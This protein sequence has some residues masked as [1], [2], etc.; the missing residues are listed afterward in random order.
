MK[1]RIC[2]MI[3]GVVFAI[4]GYA[5]TN[6]DENKIPEQSSPTNPASYRLTIDSKQRDLNGKLLVHSIFGGKIMEL[7]RASHVDNTSQL[8]DWSLTDV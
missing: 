4:H 8:E 6:G 3:I 5:Q 2:I 1:K 7:S